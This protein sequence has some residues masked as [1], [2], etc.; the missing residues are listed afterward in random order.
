M[1]NWD[2]S[3]DETLNPH[4]NDKSQLLHS[5]SEKDYRDA[6]DL[7]K[8]LKIPFH[9]ISFS[10]EYWFDVWESTLAEY[11]SGWLTPNPDILYNQYIKAGVLLAY[12]QKH[13]G[14]EKLAT[15]HYA[16]KERKV[17]VFGSNVNNRLGLG[18]N[19]NPRL[20]PV[21]NTD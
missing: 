15:G 9:R 21:E 14:I 3:V 4:A 16:R 8:I 5:C 18:N 6:Q 11:S 20:T 1:Q 12:V 17:L 7:C 19:H 2:A 13:F 10:N